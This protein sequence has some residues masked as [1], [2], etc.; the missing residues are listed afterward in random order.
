MTNS[1][2]LAHPLYEK[3]WCVVTMVSGFMLRRRQE[4]P[5]FSWVPSLEHN[6]KRHQLDTGTVGTAAHGAANGRHQQPP[7]PVLSSSFVESRTRLSL[8]AWNPRQ[9][10]H[11]PWRRRLPM[12]WLDLEALAIGEDHVINWSSCSPRPRSHRLCFR[13]SSIAPVIFF[14]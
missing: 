13:L 4:Q 5:Y 6:A 8:I 7:V 11:L 10:G 12:L 9:T 3:L 1:S 2:V 14:W